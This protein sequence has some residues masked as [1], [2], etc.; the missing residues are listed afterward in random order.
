MYLF[1]KYK[2]YSSLLLTLPQD[3]FCVGF[4]FW[5]SKPAASAFNSSA[6]PHEQSLQAF[7][8][9]VVPQTAIN[10]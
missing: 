9:P 5:F 10:K 3:D 6:K 8:L 1:G 2:N 4:G 7:L